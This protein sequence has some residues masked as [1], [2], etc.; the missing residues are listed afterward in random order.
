MLRTRLL[1][2]TKRTYSKFSFTSNEPQRHVFEQEKLTPEQNRAAI[3]T[4]PTFDSIPRRHLE[5]INPEDVSDLVTELTQDDVLVTVLSKQKYLYGDKNHIVYDKQG[6]R[7][8]QLPFANVGLSWVNLFN[9]QVGKL[10]ELKDEQTIYSSLPKSIVKK[11]D[12]VDT[13]DIKKVFE[14]TNAKENSQM[15]VGG[16]LT[17]MELLNCITIERLTLYLLDKPINLSDLITYV[18]ETSNYCTTKE[19]TIIL[20]KMFDALA[21]SDKTAESNFVKFIIKCIDTQ[22]ES[23]KPLASSQLDQLVHILAKAGHIPQA[24]TIL[25]QLVESKKCPSE[26]TL[27]EILAH[28]KD[29]NQTDIIQQLGFLK[30]VFFATKLTGNKFE[31]LLRSVQDIHDLNKLL[32]LAQSYPDIIEQYQ[33]NL[34]STLLAVNKQYPDH[35][36]RLQLTQFIRNLKNK[37]VKLNGK[38]IEVS[39]H[40]YVNLGDNINGNNL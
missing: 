22:F 6:A 28:F 35:E 33:T 38:F 30:S 40:E 37:G 2:T 23:I 36:R 3:P 27:N 16:K 13:S 31:L 1:Q 14:I 12:N 39:K 32:V 34:L 18:D 10:D 4:K 24:L 25:R 26:Q 9:K 7:S 19:L 5:I 29:S 11:L 15:K 8:V 20:S 21:N 17:P